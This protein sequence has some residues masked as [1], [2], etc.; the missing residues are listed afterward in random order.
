MTVATGKGA[1]AKAD[2]LFSQIIRSEGKC[3][4]CGSTY[5]LQCAHI[6]GRTFSWTRVHLDN[7][8]CLCGTCHYKVDNY[9]DEKM[10]L[11]EATIGLDLYYD[12]VRLSQCRDKFDWPAAAAVL[13]AEWK[14][15][16]A[17][18]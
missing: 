9:A 4:R 5:G 18:A 10:S 16:K 2:R 13:D 17:V 3:Q 14:Q 12:L 11:V 1:K 15:I 6:L 7:A 8:W